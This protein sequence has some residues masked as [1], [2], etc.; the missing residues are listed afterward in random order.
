MLV[1]KFLQ[2]KHVN[3]LEIHQGGRCSSVEI[4]LVW[5]WNVRVPK[6]ET[7]FLMYGAQ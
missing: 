7:K 1:F 6:I 2:S 5:R 4:S 3:I